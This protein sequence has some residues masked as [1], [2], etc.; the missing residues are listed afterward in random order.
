MFRWDEQT[1]MPV[2]R[3]ATT[4]ER[5][6]RIVF[7]FDPTYLAEPLP[8]S[9]LRLPVRPGVAIGPAQPFDGLFGVFDDSLPD[10]WGRL[11]LHR[12]ARALGI[13]PAALTPLD[14]LACLGDWAMGAL[15]YRP[16]TPAETPVGGVDLAGIVES[17]RQVL[18]GA[19]DDLFPEL[20][21]LG[22]SPAGAR[23]KALVCRALSDGRLMHGRTV[24]P[25]GW[26][27]WLVK[28]R[29]RDDPPE[30]GL[31]EHGYALMASAA[32]LTVS[33]SIVMPSGAGGPGLFGTR[34]FD[35]VGGA[36]RLHLHSAP[37]LLHADFRSP[38]LDYLDLARLT[39]FL[40]KDHRAGVELF[41]RAV[42]NVLAD[43]RDDHGKQFGYL[44]D[45]QGVWRFAPAYDL[46]PSDGPG[47]EHATAIAG[48]GRSPGREHM[49]KL[50]GVVG[51]AALEADRIIEQVRDA[52]S[53]WRGF[54]GDVG[55]GTGAAKRVA[56]R[57][58]V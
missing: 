40:T 44:M 49:L 13:D 14:M 26:E 36:G 10:G 9:P 55:L 27:H 57:L 30:I 2:G 25:P 48:E 16:E 1:L 41:R 39:L 11:L 38:S 54:A 4:A 17:N 33:E 31:V 15:T 20:L 46:T 37:G 58:R 43:N 24:A 12:R 34:R 7:E 32:G 28:F 50:A 45:R 29:G 3:L 18:E 35:R 42:F 5:G 22:G 47:G 8:L 52:V 56:A 6:R 23:P 19:P 53:R 21:R 51:L